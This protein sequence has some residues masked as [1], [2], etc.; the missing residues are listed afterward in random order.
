[1]SVP[2]SSDIGMPRPVRRCHQDSNTHS[3]TV[4][5]IT[6]SISKAPEKISRTMF[7]QYRSPRRPL[8]LFK[9]AILTAR[10]FVPAYI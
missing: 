7:P 9:L 1:M 5:V 2:C 4:T 10:L 6:M 3:I 8:S